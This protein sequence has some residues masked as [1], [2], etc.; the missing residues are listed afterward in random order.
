MQDSRKGAVSRGAL[1]ALAI[2]L[3]IGLVGAGQYF[4][5]A[6]TQP[7]PDVGRQTVDAFLSEV[8]AGKAGEAW[9]STTAEFKS[10]E[11]RES[12]ARSAAKAPILKEPLGFVSTQTVT[13]ADQPR[14]EFIY[15]SGESKMVRVLV[16]YEGGSWKVDRLTL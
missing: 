16:G 15:Q 9:D 14:T 11:G 5:Q 3:L 1:I 4:I 10:I 2:V 8:R 6:P 12:F 13:V 7:T